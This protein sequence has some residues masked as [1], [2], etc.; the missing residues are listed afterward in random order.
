MKVGSKVVCVDGKW[1]IPDR[2]GKITCPV[3]NGIYTVR[4]VRHS[5]KGV[6][7][8]LE[9]IVNETQR[10]NQG[11]AEPS[12]SISHFREIDEL[13]DHT[14]ESIIEELEIITVKPQTVEI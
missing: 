14:I 5:P 4:D 10:T 6:G 13:S 7:L 2:W 11:Y 1:N 9:E 3:N 8:L 12:F